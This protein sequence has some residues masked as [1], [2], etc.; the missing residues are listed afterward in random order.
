MPKPQRSKESTEFIELMIVLLV[1]IAA[2]V[3]GLQT[4]S[5][6][7]AFDTAEHDRATYAA[8]LTLLDQ[9]MRNYGPGSELV[10]RH[11]QSFTAAAI[12]GNWR[13]EAAPLGVSY[14]DV[15][16][17]SRE[18]ARSVLT[19]LMNHIGL[20]IHGHGLLP[21]L[22]VGDVTTSPAY[23]G[24]SILR[25]ICRTLRTLPHRGENHIVAGGWNS[26]FEFLVSIG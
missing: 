2:V 6:K 26:P 10:R 9:C 22:R 19:D 1:T 11:L 5:V 7:S 3:L 25:G 18:G 23:Y 20:E 13:S 8:Q 17:M 14:P 21:L 15:S 12:A 16:K 4:T 24:R